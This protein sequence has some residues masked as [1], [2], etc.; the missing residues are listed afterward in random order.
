MWDTVFPKAPEQEGR[1]QQPP[2]PSPHPKLRTEAGLQTG[3]IC[4]LK[5]LRSQLPAAMVWPWPGARHTDRSYVVVVLQ[6]LPEAPSGCRPAP[7][8]A[9]TQG[10]RFPPGKDVPQVSM[11]PEAASV[12]G[13]SAP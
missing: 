2:T 6:F 12:T 1:A 11:V 9:G 4:L 5:S 7:P 13:P 10:P 3:L 8:H